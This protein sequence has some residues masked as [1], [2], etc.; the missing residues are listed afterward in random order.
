M[1]EKINIIT[2]FRHTNII[3]S[4]RHTKQW[5]T[6]PSILRAAD[7]GEYEKIWNN[8]SHTISSSRPTKS[9]VLNQQAFRE[10]NEIVGDVRLSWLEF[11]SLGWWLTELLS[12]HA[13]RPTC[14]SAWTWAG[15]KLRSHLRRDGY[16]WTVGGFWSHEWRGTDTVAAAMSESHCYEPFH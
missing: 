13:Q 10:A 9:T 1:I 12:D 16:R 3:P 5:Q 11:Q 2:V 7:S 14:S 6:D 15:P 8:W 4:S